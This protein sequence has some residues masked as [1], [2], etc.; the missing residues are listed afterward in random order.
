MA[1][2]TWCWLSALVLLSAA[3][4]L[5]FA[6]DDPAPWIFHDELLYS[7]LAKSFAATGTFAVREVPGTGGFGI[8]Y[9]ILISPSYWLYENVTN[10]YEG[11]KAINAVLMSLTAVPTYLLARRV[12]GR[13]LALVAAVLAVA[14]PS[15]VYTSSLMT[16]VVFYPITMTFVLATALVLER[17]GA[18]RQV[19]VLALLPLA[20]FTRAQAIVFVPA[21]VTAILLVVLLDA[22]S[23]RDRFAPRDFL[24]RLLAFRIIWLAL[25]GGALAY[26][27]LQ[28]ARGQSLGSAALG[29]YGVLEYEDYSAA[30]IFRWFVYS[31]AE[32]D[33]YLGVLPFA[34][35]LLLG[36]VAL[37]PGRHSRSLRIFAAFSVAFVFWFTFVVAAFASTS[38]GDRI[39]ERNLFYVAPIFLIA[40][41]VW[42]DRGLPRPRSAAAIAALVAAALPGVLPYSQLIDDNAV[43]GALAFLPLKRL[44]EDVLTSTDVPY[45]VVLGAMAVAI[46]MLVVPRRF[47]LTV[48]ALVLLY[49]AVVQIH[50]EH[51]TSKASRDALIGSGLLDRGWIDQAVGPDADVAALWSGDA[52]FVTLWE[53]EFFNRAVGPVYNFSRPP[54]GLP[55]ETLAIDPA[56]GILRDQAGKEIRPRYVLVDRTMNLD[57]RVVAGSR[58][59]GASLRLYEASQPVIVRERTH[60]LYADSW[61]GGQVVY[62]RYGC[63]GGVLGL[64][65][66]SDRALHRTPVSVVASS[67]GGIRAQTR[68]G[69]KP[70]F[71]RVPVAPEGGSCQ[72][73][74]AI[75]P[76]ATPADILGTAD[77]RQLGVRFRAFAFVPD[78]P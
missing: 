69:R 34:A 3:I 32:F 55:Q 20:F 61:S 47:A 24:R 65:L 49:F 2:P 59:P 68:V 45:V 42:V 35:F 30:S 50:V 25:A 36:A 15:M 27:V 64:V 29:G 18:L 19:F 74:F 5:D 63:T 72:V 39:E 14:V 57:G 58:A 56:S 52:P 62:T 51:Y 8:V 43:A 71:L 21:L 1:V 16:E 17:P 77:T 6:L 76:L 13:G 54:D 67:G 37:R 44:Q 28:L 70:Q 7:E 60:G 31:V 46:L 73:E 33:L 10:A 12:L 38:F 78:V 41:L 75:S 40:M 53:N 66:V 11:V 9:P 23:S 26:V 4:R 48:P 22:L